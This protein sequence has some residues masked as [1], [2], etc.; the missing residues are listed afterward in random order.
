MTGLTFDEITTNKP[1]KALT[2]SLKKHAG[3]NNT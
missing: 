2:V 1:Y 3:R